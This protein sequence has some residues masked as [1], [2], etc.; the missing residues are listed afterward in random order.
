MEDVIP[1]LPQLVSMP[2][3]HS[4]YRIGFRDKFAEVFWTIFLQ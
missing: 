2:F 3:Y 4:P 1:E